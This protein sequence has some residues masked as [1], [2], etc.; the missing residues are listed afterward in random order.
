MDEQS[1]SDA[2]RT[3][4]QRST[5]ERA[6]EDRFRVAQELSLD[7]FTILD[8]IRDEAGVIQDFCC[9][10]VNPAAARLLQRERETLE[11]ARLDDVLPGNRTSSDLF[12][13][14][15]RVVETG[16]PHDIEI[17]YESA[18]RRGWF[19]NMAVKL[20][21]GVAVSLSE[22]TARKHIELQLR[23]RAEELAALMETVPAVTFIAHDP[24][25]RL[26][27]GN[28]AGR[29]IL[30]MG[31]GR[32]LSKTAP[33]DEAPTH[34][35]VFSASGVELAMEEL[36]I[37]RAAG[38]E[39]VRD[40]EE[41]VRFDDGDVVFLF[42]SA[43]PLHDPNGRARG[44]VGSFVDITKLKRLEAELKASDRRKDEFLAMLAHELRNPLAPI[45]NSIE[46]LERLG[47]F[48]PRV[49]A[50]HATIERQL[51][52]LTRLV[53]DLLDVSRITQNK[54]TLRTERLD[55][56]A[57][58]TRAIETSRPVIE[59]RRHRL[60]VSMPSE[61]LRVRGDLTRLAQ[62]VSNLLNNAA[63]YTDVGGNIELCVAREGHEVVIRVIDDGIGI[64]ADVLPHVFDLFAQADRSLD[65]SQGGLGIGLTLVHRLVQMHGGRVEAFSGG[66]G[67]GTQLRVDL[68]LALDSMDATTSSTASLEPT[69]TEG[70]SASGGRK[71]VLVVD[72]SE[73]AAE[74][75]A[76]LLDISGYETRIAHDG[77]AALDVARTFM[78]QVVLLDI[79]LPGMDGHEVA[80]C[81][82]AMPE[83]RDAYIIALTGYG[84][85]E[86]RRRSL[87][88]GCDEHLTKPVEPEL[89][90]TVLAKRA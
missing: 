20:Q 18:G 11:G 1:T 68:P 23:E 53:D 58:I 44:A 67:T 70:V 46:V 24:D 13:R 64:T 35:S 72:D 37:Q 69:V 6:N 84:G 10:Y 39:E 48:E 31:P 17:H 8:A 47:P 50:L 38:G 57:V 52:Q 51:A 32:N 45:R 78:P 2:P 25:A 89:L 66:R 75:M 76:M 27:T 26:I 22:I 21:D 73:D 85:A 9:T 29:E 42:G 33:G 61:P 54:I 12:D 79:G 4:A 55:V 62:V 40:F 5:A 56:S 81:L 87:A 83:T 14:Y 80:R 90:E 7:A 82:R 43:V 71:R 15:V 34:F 3:P 86:D 88:A 77:G 60:A 65:R 59:A 74:S 30:K 41:Q 28:R 36:P 63:K 16:E 19:R 49:M